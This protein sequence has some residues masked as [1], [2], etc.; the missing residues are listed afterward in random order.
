MAS[1]EIVKAVEKLG[2]GLGLRIENGIS[3]AGIGFERMLCPD[4]VTQAD[5]VLVAGA[6]TIPVISSIGKKGTKDA[7]LHV[8]HGHMLMK[9]DFE[10]FGW[11]GAQQFGQ[12]L[13]V[14]V[15]GSGKAFQAVPSF[16]VIRAEWIGDVQGEIGDAARSRKRAEM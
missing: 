2:A 6:A 11:R 10:P 12:L 15:I 7:M 16:E 3:A 14:Q 13:G 4:A 1:A 8:K 9:G 5:I